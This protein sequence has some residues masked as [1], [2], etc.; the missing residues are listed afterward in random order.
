M[1]KE[2]ILLFGTY[3]VRGT[4]KSYMEKLKEKDMEIERLNELVKELREERDYLFNKTTTESNYEIERLHSIIKEVR[5]YVN[6]ELLSSNADYYRKNGGY[7]SGSDLDVDCIFPIL[8]IL[9]KE[10]K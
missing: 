6:V 2:D 4:G 8:D 1:S 3:G 10:N 7:V 9:D 5:E